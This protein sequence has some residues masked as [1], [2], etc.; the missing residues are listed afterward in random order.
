MAFA[1][2]MALLGFS[3]HLRND[4]AV[5]L[6]YFTGRL[7]TELSL[8]VVG[9]IIIGVMLGVLAMFITVLRLKREMRRLTRCNEKIHGELVATQANS[10]EDVH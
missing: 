10:S 6:N 8:V 3:F 5:V 4:Q 7:E 1:A 2:L 9:A